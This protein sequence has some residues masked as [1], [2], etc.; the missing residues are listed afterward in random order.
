MRCTILINNHNYE[1]YLRQCI[2]SAIGQSV[3]VEVVVVDDGSTDGSREVIESFGDRVRGIYQQNAGQAAAINAGLAVAT[4]DVIALLDADDWFFPI[5][6][7]AVVEAFR[8]NPTVTWLRHDFVL[9]DEQGTEE[10]SSLYRFPRATTPRE[11]YVR[12]GETVGAT[13]CLAFRRSFLELV[14]GEVPH[15]FVGYAD[16][17]LRCVAAL[18]GECVDLPE[19]LAARR[20]HATQISSPRGG[21]APR[22]E[23]RVRYKQ[24]LAQKAATIGDD[25]GLP[26]ISAASAWWQHKAFVHAS[27]LDEPLVRR[28]KSWKRYVA[29]LRRSGLPGH[30]QLAFGARE[31]VLSA[32]PRRAF[33]ALWWWT[34]DGRPRLK[35]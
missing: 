30:T 33:P 4:G 13:S 20:M 1:R 11:D 8:D 35:S 5:K 32:A 31:A 10:Q 25:A 14:V 18:L 21:T 12:W 26:D 28:L 19:S 15:L 22:V 6:A 2:E 24:A 29:T 16:T 23:K 17:Y 34:N 27:C 7:A 3:D 9:V